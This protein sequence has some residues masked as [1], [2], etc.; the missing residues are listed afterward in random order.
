MS[1][2]SNPV[3]P[4]ITIVIA[5]DHSLF[6]QGLVILLEKEMIEVVGEAKD[7]NE[8]LEK[9]RELKPEVVLTDIVMPGL[10]GIEATQI[11]VKEFPEIKVIRLTMYEEEHYLIEMMKA[12]AKG[13]LFKNLRKQE[14]LR[15]IYTVSS[16]E[17]Y[18]SNNVSNKFFRL[19][20]STHFPLY[21]PK[22]KPYFNERALLIIQLICDQYSSQEIAEHLQT[23]R[24]VIESH[25]ERIQKKIKAKNVIGI[26]IY[27]IKNGFY[28]LLIIFYLLT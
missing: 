1:L 16:G 3:H 18:Y 2:N 17:F 4:K 5:E 20:S 11:I 14:L 21:L 6:R 10:S 28:H 26:V 19:F 25:R 23:N 24:R 22:A 12:G 9:V 13:Y 15:A 8:L 7:G 27:A